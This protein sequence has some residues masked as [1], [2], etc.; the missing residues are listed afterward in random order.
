MRTKQTS[1][2]KENINNVF[3]GR[4]KNKKTVYRNI[5]GID[6]VPR[7]VRE[8]DIGK[9]EERIVFRLDWQNT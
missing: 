9:E 4:L 6:R 1:Y 2:R 5:K 8:K 3:F 7:R